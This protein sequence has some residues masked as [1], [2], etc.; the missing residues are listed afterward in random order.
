MAELDWNDLRYLL[1]VAR[2]GKLSAA[3]ARLKA[4]HATVS[5]RISAL[6]DALQT[7]LLER[8]TTGCTLTEQGIKLIESA[9]AIEGIA[10]GSLSALAQGGHRVSGAVRIGAPEG[11]GSYFLAP[12]LGVLCDRYPEL[13]IELVAV[14][15]VFS[16]S[17]READIVICLTPP[18]HGRVYSRKLTD[19]RMGLY[20]SNEYFDAHPAIETPEDFAKHRIIGYIDDLVFSSVL[21][22]MLDENRLP[23][24]KFRSSNLIAQMKATVAGAGIC[25]LPSFIAENH[26]RLRPVLPRD[27]SVERSFWMTV[28]ADLR[29]VVR[30]RE[31]CNFIESTVREARTLFY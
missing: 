4:N 24:A 21:S 11:F 2:T 17:K 3:A 6:E 22:N 14:G 1:A 13:E 8:R 18:E 9:E 5:R 10:L 19:Y 16:L 26:A 12:R 30:V 29:N 25:L 28:H 7:K 20:A 23:V 27:V 15:Q 31:T